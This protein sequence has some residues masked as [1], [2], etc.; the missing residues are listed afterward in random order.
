MDELSDF[1]RQLIALTRAFGWHRPDE[2]PCGRP[3]P[4]AEAHALLEL[5]RTPGLTQKQLGEAIN[6][7]KS[8]VSRLVGNLER[9]E[10][11]ARTKCPS[12]GRAV[13]I[14]LTEKGE[15]MAGQMAEARA[16]KMSG[17]LQ[18][19]PEASRD[20]VLTALDTLV[21]AVRASGR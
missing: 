12:D 20:E 1:Q 13:R 2:T 6:L 14:A 11:A 8:T 15:R 21:R 19:I 10:W 18:A 3:V 16:A 4:I 7:R 5:S 17:I 9:R